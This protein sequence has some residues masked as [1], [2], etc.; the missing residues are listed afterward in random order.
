MTGESSRFCSERHSLRANAH[1]NS[2]Q[3]TR[4]ERSRA[5]GRRRFLSLTAAGALAG[6][7]TAGRGRAQETRT[8]ELGGK[9]AGW[10]GR[11]PDSI[12]NE[13]NPTLALEAGVDYRITWTNLDGMGHN[14]ALVD[15]NGAVIERTAV[16]SEQGATQTLE[17]TAREAMAEYICEPHRSSMRGSV[18]FGADGT[19]SATTT[20]SSESAVPTGPTIGLERVVG[21]FEVPTDM[22][23]LPR[24]VSYLAGQR[25]SDLT[26]GTN[27]TN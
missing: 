5:V 10:Q 1:V 20:E 21:G 3:H 23:L 24:T 9:I 7:V 12:A 19:E 6:V 13:E 15:G 11:A 2:I 25:P 16:M 22:A 18:R 17:F 26:P 4:N 14:F 8:I 27:Y